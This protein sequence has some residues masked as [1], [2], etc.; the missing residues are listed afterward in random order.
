MSRLE[1]RAIFSDFDNAFAVG[2]DEMDVGPIIGRQI[3]VVEARPFAQDMYHGLSASAVAFL[4]D[5]LDARVDAHHVVDV[6]F[7]WRRIFSSRG[8]AAGRPFAL[9]SASP[10]ALSLF[11]RL[12]LPAGLQ[13]PAH[14][15][16]VALSSRMSTADGVRW[17]T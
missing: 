6:W 11:A 15:G 10:A 3:V 7:S 1:H 17:K 8:I 14:S 4:D 5:F 12:R 16:S 13:L 2:I 9:R